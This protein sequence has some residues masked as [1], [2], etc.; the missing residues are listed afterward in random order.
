MCPPKTLSKFPAIYVVDIV[1]P[2]GLS[3]MGSN[4][5]TCMII[6]NNVNQLEIVFIIHIHNINVHLVFCSLSETLASCNI[7]FTIENMFT[8]A[9]FDGI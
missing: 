4:V 1:C 8:V 2:I 3:A 5:Y 6:Q 7:Y 9:L